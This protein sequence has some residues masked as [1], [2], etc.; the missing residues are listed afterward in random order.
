MQNLPGTATMLLRKAAIMTA[1]GFLVIVLAGPII[2]LIGT[3][4]PFLIVGFLVWLVVRMVI[5]GPIVVGRFIGRTV[6]GIVSLILAGPRWVFR[7]VRGGV[8][9]V[10]SGVGRVSGFARGIFWETL[11]GGA[12]GAML[13]MIGGM[14]H[15]DA[16]FR[17]P[18]GAAIGASIG[19]LAA[20]TRS[21][22]PREQVAQAIPVSGALHHG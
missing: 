11:C 7:R 19:L 4:L 2:G 21:R 22:A 18:I 10:G 6:R 15:Q 1:I 16:E 17:V 12:V 14:N 20:A 8:R 3:L 13:G 9:L 5:L